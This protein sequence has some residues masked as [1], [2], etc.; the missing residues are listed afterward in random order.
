MYSCR[1]ALV[2]FTPP[3]AHLNRVLNTLSEWKGLGRS[4]WYRNYINSV[5]WLPTKTSWH[6]HIIPL[7]GSLHWL[8]AKFRIKFNILLIT[9][10]AAQFGSTIYQQVSHS[11]TPG[12]FDLNVQ[13]LYIVFFFAAVKH[14]V[15]LALKSPIWIKG[16]LTNNYVN[17][18]DMMFQTQGTSQVNDMKSHN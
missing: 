18:V 3:T 13:M 16:L 10:K 9:F 8:P 2:F 14:F 11:K 15:T 1:T 5:A 17:S 4:C 6:S 12:V 7:L